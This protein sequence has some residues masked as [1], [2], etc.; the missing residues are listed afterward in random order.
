MLGPIICEGRLLASSCLSFP[1]SV[2]PHILARF[3]LDGFFV[4]FDFGDFYE[5]L[6]RD[7]KLVR[8][9]PK[10]HPLYIKT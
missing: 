9:E 6:V 4:K 2:Y 5:N 3:T 10:Y 7:S 8:V 1:L